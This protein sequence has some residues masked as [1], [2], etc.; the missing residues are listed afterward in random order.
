MRVKK[1]NSSAAKAEFKLR[2]VGKQMAKHL[3][4]LEIY[5]VQDLLFHL[6]SRYQDR[7]HIES[8]DQ[9]VQ[10]KEAVVEGVIHTVSMPQRGRTKLL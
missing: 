6:P 2:G 10:G 4:R 1:R 3:E 8:I 7:T 9:L 5:S